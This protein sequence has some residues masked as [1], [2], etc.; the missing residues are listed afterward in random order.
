MSRAPSPHP[1]PPLGE[2]ARRGV[3]GSIGK[4][5]P[6]TNGSRGVHAVVRFLAQR[7]GKRPFPSGLL[8]GK[9]TKHDQ[10]A[11]PR[12]CQGPT[13]PQ[14]ARI[15][16]A[17]PKRP[18]FFACGAPEGMIVLDLNLE[19]D[20]PA[21][22]ELNRC[23]LLRNAMEVGTSILPDLNK[24]VRSRQTG[25]AEVEI[26]VSG[27]RCVWKTVG[28]GINAHQTQFTDGRMKQIGNVRTTASSAGPCRDLFHPLF[29]GLTDD[30]SVRKAPRL[31]KAAVSG[32]ESCSSR[33]NVAALILSFSTGRKG[34]AKPLRRDAF[35]DIDARLRSWPGRQR[36]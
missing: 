21:A 8:S 27:C 6:Q 1:Y 28:K 14:R 12:G 34:R 35:G 36:R 11:R 26:R 19:P 22:R 7:P 4:G 5:R 10:G 25:R 2:G 30:P 24:P 32:V 15:R 16:D 17:D 20:L 23:R 31:A 33:A 13:I 18:E 29:P 3:R 9:G